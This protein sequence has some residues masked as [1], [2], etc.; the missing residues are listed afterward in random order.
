[1]AYW[2]LKSDPETYSWEKMK[3]EKKTVWDGVR[4]YQARN[5]LASMLKGD[6]ALFYHSNA[7]K[8]VF[9]IVEISKIAFQDPSTDDNRWLAVEIKYKKQLKR[10]V[11][12]EQMKL[13]P[14]LA[15]I[16][17]IKQSRL[18]VMPLSD[19]EFNHIIHLSEI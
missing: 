1:M 11:S 17:L 12:L 4:N 16:G 19:A 18:S 6:L 8:S 9:G 2:L 10:P 15:N 13:E 3:L 7:E 14:L 5:N